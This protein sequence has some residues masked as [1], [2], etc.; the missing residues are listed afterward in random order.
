MPL[1]LPRLDHPGRRR[2]LGHAEH[3][4]RR[5]P[6]W[7]YLGGPLGI[8]AAGAVTIDR[9]DPT[10]NTIYVGTGEANICGSGCVAGVGLYK[11]TNGGVTWTGPI[12]KA[13]ARRQG[14]RRDHH[15]A[16]R[17][18][19]ALRRHDDRAARH[20]ERL[21]L[22]RH[23]PGP[24]RRRSGASTSPPTAATTWTFIHNGSADAAE[25]TGSVDRVQQRRDLLA[26][27][28]APRRARPGELRTSST[29]SSYARG[30]WRSTDAGATWTQIKPSLNAAV[31]QTRAALRRDR[32]CPTARP[33]C[34]STR[35]TSAP[36][37]PGCS[38]ATTSP[39]ARRRSPT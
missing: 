13:R 36:R 34:T 24:G 22:R 11:S 3:A 27:R 30:I 39:P 10:G 7:F 38:A 19:D 31:I 9:N 37:T 17:P 6:K 16:G 2:R 4:R 26:A 32:S 1:L 25:C 18:E 28:R 14:H 5:H 35:A 23:P 21:L 29:P 15:Q 33:G 20:V 12:G 8:N